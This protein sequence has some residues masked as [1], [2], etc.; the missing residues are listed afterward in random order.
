M[1]EAAGAGLMAVRIT[2][3]G[4]LLDVWLGFGLLLVSAGI[5]TL[6][7]VT[8]R[9]SAG[10][11][12]LRFQTL[13]RRRSVPWRAA[14]RARNAAAD[15]VAG[16]AVAR[17][18]VRPG[19]EVIEGDRDV[20][21]DS[22]HAREDPIRRPNSSLTHGACAG[23][24]FAPTAHFLLTSPNRHSVSPWSAPAGAALG[25]LVLR[26]TSVR[27]PASWAGC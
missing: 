23:C 22:R 8:A 25:G 11:Y 3:C 19:D 10:A 15:P 26:L 17:A 18:G 2:Y 21:D 7:V 9:V 5:A 13:L 4:E 16:P 24:E 14:S 12:S 20:S 6:R 1:W 27:A